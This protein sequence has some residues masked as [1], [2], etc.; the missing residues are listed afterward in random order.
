MVK[1]AVIA[2]LVPTF[3]LGATGCGSIVHGRTQAITVS[4]DPSGATVY[5]E[6]APRGETPT[7]IE[8][9]RRP[10]RVLLTLKKPGYEEA[11]LEIANGVSMWALLGNFVFGGI[12]G[13]VIDA[14]TGSFGAYHQDSYKVALDPADDQ[15]VSETSGR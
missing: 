1:K 15:A 12:P 4:S 10:S 9:S 5:Y 11:E 8:V 3:I 7:T 2:I 13:W 14:A 6:G